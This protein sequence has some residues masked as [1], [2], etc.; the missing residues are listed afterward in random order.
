M[1]TKTLLIALLCVS[2]FYFQSCT[3]ID[4]TEAGFKISKSGSYRGL[5]SIPLVTGW[6]FYLPWATEVVTIPTTMQHEVW[7]DS[8]DE[9][10]EVGQAI[11]IACYG[12]AGFKID[13]GFN[14]HVDYQKA[15]KIYLRFK[16]DDLSKITST[17]LRN[18]VR[19][20][21]Q[22]VSSHMTVD[23]VL[24]NQSGMELSITKELTKR[25]L[26]DGFVLDNFSINSKPEP[27]DPTLAAAI[28]NKI[29]AR[30][31]AETSKMQLQI[32]IADANKK[33]ASARGDSSVAVIE[34]AGRAEAI[35]K[36]QQQLTPEYVEYTRVQKWD[37]AYPS[38][39]LGSSPNILF[40][41]VHK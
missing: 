14:Y 36:L 30:Q 9:G 16:T 1:K 37:G 25:L 13:V 2:A 35:R 33:I 31:D 21:M 7:S 32:S 12:G 29:K 27:T 10:K 17:Y 38:T 19:Q 28:N 34:A 5:D 24:N 20:S 6:Q 15:S 39:M 18:L 8:Q 26:Q 41:P 22:D 23:S 40:Q 4:P 3:R 11:K